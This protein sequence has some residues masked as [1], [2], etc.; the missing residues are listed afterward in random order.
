MVT[1]STGD[2]SYPSYCSFGMLML[3]PKVE[4]VKVR[5]PMA[6]RASAVSWCGTK[7]MRSAMS[8]NAPCGGGGDRTG[9]QAGRQGGA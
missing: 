8:F 3:A 7:T 2:S 1:V 6:L 4:W 5:K 9:R